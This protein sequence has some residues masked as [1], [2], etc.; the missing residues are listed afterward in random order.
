MQLKLYK[1]STLIL[2]AGILFIVGASVVLYMNRELWADH[3]EMVY[4]PAIIIVFIFSAFIVWYDTNVDKR[5]IEKMTANGKIA[6]ARINGGTFVRFIRNARMQQQVLWQLDLT[7]YDQD[8]NEIKTTAIEKF[9]SHQTS[10]PEGNVY[11]TWDPAKPDHV[12]VIPNILL[13]AYPALKDIVEKY[14]KNKKIKI[15][16]LNSYYDKGMILRT[17]RDTIKM[18]GKK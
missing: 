16:Y 15:S 11:V 3:R 7:V 6:L 10:I 13:S 9:S 14:E 18:E 5:I 4:L 8:M 1:R 12:F 17:F 2:L